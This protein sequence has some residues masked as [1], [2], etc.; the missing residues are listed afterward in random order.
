VL[1]STPG[2]I[3]A[4]GGES[5]YMAPGELWWFNHQVE[6]YVINTGPA[7]THIIMDLCAPGFTGALQR[8]A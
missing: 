3:F 4:A 2:C 5:Q 6:H 8:P 7:R 1:D